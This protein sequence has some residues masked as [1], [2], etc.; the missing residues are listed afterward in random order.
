MKKSVR[1]LCSVFGFFLTLT[2]LVLQLGAATW[3]FFCNSEQVESR[4]CTQENA[5]QTMELI[6]RE[7]NAVADS[8]GIGH[9]V[10]DGVFTEETILA[11]MKNALHLAQTEQAFVPLYWDA[12]REKLAEQVRQELRELEN[13]DDVSSYETDIRSF[14]EQI[15]DSYQSNISLKAYRYLPAAVST[16]KKFTALGG[17]LSAAVAA[18]CVGML[19]ILTHRG[20]MLLREISFS[21][22]AAGGLC[23]AFMAYL[24]QA[25][26]FQ[27][28]QIAPE[29]L[30]D[31]LRGFLHDGFAWTLWVG[32]VTL[33]A[34][35]L[36]FFLAAM[37]SQRTK[38]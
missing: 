15:A 1:F 36:C 4:L 20:W 28:I 5:Q 32:V 16:A 29:F 9:R 35:I 11:E 17:I 24:L 31:A 2:C 10:F 38:R 26:P 18:L 6:C 21:L 13:M 14:L 33:A 23:T 22:T 34:G 30:R 7:G 3:G 37:C 12:A 25:K 8:C 27:K 19:W